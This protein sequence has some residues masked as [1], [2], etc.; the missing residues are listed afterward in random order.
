S[1]RPFTADDV[2][3]G[4]ELF[5]GHRRLAGGG[6]PCVSCHSVNGIGVLA[7]GALGPDLNEVFERL[8]GRRGLMTWLSA[9]ATSTM[10]AV[11][12]P[13]P[14]EAEEEILPLTA[15]FADLAQEATES[16]QAATLIFVLLGLAGTAGV[17]M[18]FDA[19]WGGRFRSVRSELVDKSAQRSEG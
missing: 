3:H 8:N 12:A 2:R 19:V 17:L 16:T 6:P 18:I 9:P 15:Y 14:L 7:G 5:L 1:D 10:G 11:Y 13:H 4:R